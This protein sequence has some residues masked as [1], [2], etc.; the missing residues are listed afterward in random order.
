MDR[1]DFV[2]MMQH[3]LNAKECPKRLFAKIASTIWFGKLGKSKRANLNIVPVPVVL[4]EE[5]P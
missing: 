1:F 5:S 3:F 2:K 4:A